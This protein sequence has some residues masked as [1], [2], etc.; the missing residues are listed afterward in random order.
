MRRVLERITNRLD[1]VHF[2]YEAGPTLSPDPVARLRMH[3][4]R[5]I[6]NPKEAGRSC[7]DQPPGRC[8]SRPVA[9]CRRANGC[10]GS[11]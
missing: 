1:R 2:C 6:A 5:A 10:V 3:G 9:A 11:R 8:F 4:G 7:E